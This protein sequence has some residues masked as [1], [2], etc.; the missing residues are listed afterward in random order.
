LSAADEKAGKTNTQA[1]PEIVPDGAMTQQEAE[2]MLQAI[3]D[4]E[5]LRRLRRLATERNQ[6]VQVDRDW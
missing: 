5:M 1:K 2:K 3:R 4:Q 6:H